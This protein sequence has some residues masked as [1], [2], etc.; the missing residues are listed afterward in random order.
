LWFSA[1]RFFTPPISAERPQVTSVCQQP[2]KNGEV[3]HQEARE[4]MVTL[5]FPGCLGEMVSMPIGIVLAASHQVPLLMMSQY[6]AAG[7]IIRYGRLDSI[8]TIQR[9]AKVV[10]CAPIKKLL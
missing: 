1:E 6:S 4:F 2:F 7:S 3:S 10:P 5:Q 8:P 9:S